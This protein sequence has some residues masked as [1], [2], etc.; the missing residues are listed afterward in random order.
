MLKEIIP[1]VLINTLLLHIPLLALTHRQNDRQ[2]NKLLLVGLGNLRFLQ[3]NPG[4]AGTL[5]AR[6]LEELFFQ[7]CRRVSFFVVAGNRFRCYLPTIPVVPLCLVAQVSFLVVAGKR[8]RCYLL[9]NHASCAIVSVFWF[10]REIVFG[11]TVSKK[12]SYSV[13]L[14]ESGSVYLSLY[15]LAVMIVCQKYQELSLQVIIS[16]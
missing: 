7:L 6:G 16:E 13:S 8:F 1:F 2:R 11:C 4:W 10:Q 14:R 3:V 12:D 15:L 5:A 9:T